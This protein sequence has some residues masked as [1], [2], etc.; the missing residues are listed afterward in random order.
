MDIFLCRAIGVWADR[1]RMDIGRSAT[2]D[3]K[4]LR[5]DGGDSGDDRG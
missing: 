1:W 2:A 5:D 4:Q 3:Q